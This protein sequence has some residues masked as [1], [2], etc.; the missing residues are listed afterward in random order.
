MLGATSPKGVPEAQALRRHFNSLV[1]CI[2]D[3]GPVA[4][5]AFSEG[6]ISQSVLEQATHSTG[7]RM[8]RNRTLLQAIL[9]HV[10][11][12]PSSLKVFIRILKKERVYEHLAMKLESS[13]RKFTRHIPYSTYYKPL[14]YYK[15]TPC[16]ELM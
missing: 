13:L 9:S 15:P 1:D 3:P 11:E 7:L 12:Q 14:M 4:D 2:Q 8:G 10:R 5:S 16:S 6:L